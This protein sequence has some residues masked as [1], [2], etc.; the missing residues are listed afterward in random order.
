[1][2][3]GVIA[4]HINNATSGGLMVRVAPEDFLRLVHQQKE[5]LVVTSQRGIFVTM[6]EYLTTYKGLGFVTMSAAELSLPPSAEVVQVK[7]M[8]LPV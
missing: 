1:M 7:S 8:W 5:P 2:S 6:H 3:G 4:G